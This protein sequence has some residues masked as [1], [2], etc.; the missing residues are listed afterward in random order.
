M[1]LLHAIP[2]DIALLLLWDCAG[3]LHYHLGQIVQSAISS[4]GPQDVRI[5]PSSPV[6]AAITAMTSEASLDVIRVCNVD[7]LHLF[8]LAVHLCSFTHGSVWASTFY[9]D[10]SLSAVAESLPDTH[11]DHRLIDYNWSQQHWRM[12]IEISFSLTYG[13]QHSFMHNASRW[14]LSPT[15]HYIKVLTVRGMG[16]QINAS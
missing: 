5:V 12:Q 4:G 8:V 16:V 6:I 10:S 15:F 2:F 14:Q 13:M 11:L 3:S 7:A 9:H 1:Q